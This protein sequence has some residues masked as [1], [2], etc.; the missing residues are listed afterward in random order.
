VLHGTTD[1]NRVAAPTDLLTLPAGT[2]TLT[3]EF[4]GNGLLTASSASQSVVIE[5]DF[6][7]SSLTIPGNELRWGH[8]DPM[9]V[10]LIKPNDGQDEPPLPIPGKSLTV[11]LTGPLGTQ[12][13]PAGPTS[14]F[15][16]ATITPLMTLPPGNYTATACFAQDPWFRAS[17]SAGRTVK[18]TGGFAGFSRGGPLTVSGGHNTTLLTFKNDQTV[19]GIYCVTGNIK[20]QSQVTGSAV[21]LATGKASTSGGDQHISTAD[22]LGADLLMLA[23]SSDSNAIGLQQKDASFAGAIVAAGGVVIGF[24]NSLYDGSLVGQSATLGGTNNTLDGR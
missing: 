18:V 7:A 4:A 17:C 8:D 1:D 3:V 14:L 12:S 10:T 19:S 24:T 11:T 9:S 21:L 13:Y 5:R 15:G 16:V 22:P 6:T 2:L 20:I 23:G